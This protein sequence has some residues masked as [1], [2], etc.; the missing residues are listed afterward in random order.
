MFYTWEKQSTVFLYANNELLENTIYY[1]SRKKKKLFVNLTNYVQD[2]YAGNYKIMMKE[3]REC[4]NKW[5]EI[6]CSWM[7]ILNSVFLIISVA[8]RIQFLAV[9]GLTAL[10]PC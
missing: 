8:G 3:I 10:F 1:S 4:L 6:L 9:V 2:F 7:K 5:R